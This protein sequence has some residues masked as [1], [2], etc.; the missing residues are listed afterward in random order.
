M[1]DI[2][3]SDVVL[4]NSDSLNKN[5]ASSRLVINLVS[6]FSSLSARDVFSVRSAANNSTTIRLMNLVKHYPIV[7][8]FSSSLSLTIYLFEVNYYRNV[9]LIIRT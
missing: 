9:I 7:S 1:T 8:S 5:V 3:S 4:Q 2:S 6:L